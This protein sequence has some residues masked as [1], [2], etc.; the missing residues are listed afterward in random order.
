MR[1]FSAFSISHSSLQ[2]RV[3]LWLAVRDTHV[4]AHLQQSCAM[5]VRYD[6]TDLPL[7]SRQIAQPLLLACES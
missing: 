2:S 3:M 7:P 1:K 4:Q 6:T 5:T